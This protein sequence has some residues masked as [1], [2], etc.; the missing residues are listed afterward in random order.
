M[1]VD[2]ILIAVHSLKTLSKPE[3]S[4]VRTEVPEDVSDKEQKTDESKNG[5]WQLSLA[6][7]YT[8]SKTIGVDT[9]EINLVQAISQMSQL[10]TNQT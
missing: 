8:K 2:N 1:Y 4:R 6:Q 9:I 7:Q 10:S 3:Q 5:P